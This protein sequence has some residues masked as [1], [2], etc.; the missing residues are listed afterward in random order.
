MALASLNLSVSAA[1]NDP[2]PVESSKFSHQKFRSDSKFKTKPNIIVIMA[3]DLGYGDLSCYGATEVTTPNIDR[4]AKNGLQFTQGY[5]SASTCTPT[6]FSFLTGKYAFRQPGAGIAP[7]NAT[8]LVKP[9]T[10]TIAS[11]LKKA[12]YSTSVIGK[13]HLGLG[14]D[15]APDWNNAI[16]PGPLEIGFDYCFL[17]PTTNDRVPSVYVEN[18]HVL[19]LDPKDPLWVGSKKPSPDHPVGKDPEVRKN[20]KMD[21]S[22]GHNQTV[23]NG[24]G[25]IGFYTGG[26][27]ARWRDE[28]LADQWVK[29]SN[30]W[31]EKQKDNPFFLFFS[32]H[33]IHVPRMPHER[34]QGK[35]TLGYRGDAIVQLDWCVGELQKT[36]ERLGLTEDTMFVF[37]SD[38]GPVLDDG[39]Q[40]GAITKL[41]KHK[42]SGVYRGGKY[43][44]YEGGT[45]TPFITTWQ[46]TIKPGLSEQMVCTIDLATSVA[47]ITGQKIAESAFPDSFD[48]ADALLGKENA[49]G[50]DHLLQQ[51]NRGP[52]LALR[53]GDWKVLSYANSKPQKHLT[54]QKAAGKY[55][56][57]DLSNDPAEKNNLAKQNP[58]RL[59]QMLERLEKIKTDGRTRQR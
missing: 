5:C 53:I 46:G 38:N 50:R 14:A 24:I 28:D 8:A 7:P 13:W 12:G 20:L 52:T 21:W 22:H 56:L 54:Y 4:L 39:Y 1:A 59:K 57:Y 30:K 43:S 55:E 31:I 45:R 42:P 27:S 37:C 40:D 29:Q 10:E 23:H 32:S 15:P 36:I 26:E 19:N 49:K 18:H 6:R 44:I 25:R 35:T 3:D 17:L 34:F 47:K 48:V 33:D 58:Q 9:G 16:K 51:P 11:I 41:G 2:Q